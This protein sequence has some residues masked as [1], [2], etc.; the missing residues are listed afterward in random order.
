MSLNLFSVSLNIFSEDKATQ[1]SCFWRRVDKEPGGFVASVVS[2][3]VSH[4][5][6]ALTYVR[7]GVGGVLITFLGVSVPFMIA[8]GR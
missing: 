8:W 5:H 2:L 4:V 6:G 1:S 3:S 7:G